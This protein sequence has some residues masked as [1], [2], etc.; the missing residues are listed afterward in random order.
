MN[1]NKNNLANKKGNLLNKK[2]D[3]ESKIKIL[4]EEMSQVDGEID[5]VEDRIKKSREINLKNLSYDIIDY[6]KDNFKNVDH[7]EE[8]S[9]EEGHYWNDSVIAG[10]EFSNIVQ[11]QNFYERKDRVSSHPINSSN[12]PYIYDGV[13]AMTFFI[14]RKNVEDMINKHMN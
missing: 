9:I 13:V 11:I 2:E 5:V 12:S 6:I 10:A 7:V 4:Y 3:L 1:E 14:P 8:N